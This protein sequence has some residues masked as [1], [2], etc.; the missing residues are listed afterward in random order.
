MLKSIASRLE[1]IS[2]HPDDPPDQHLR[3]NLIERASF[4]FAIAAIIWR[5]ARIQLSVTTNYTLSECSYPHLKYNFV[6]T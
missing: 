1:K 3:K 6:L 4:L 2:A 5:R